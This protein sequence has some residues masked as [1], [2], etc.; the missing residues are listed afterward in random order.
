MRPGPSRVDWRSSCVS[1]MKSKAPSSVSK[2]SW[3]PSS[4]PSTSTTASMVE[5]Q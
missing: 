3:P 5:T 4:R 1:T 2:R